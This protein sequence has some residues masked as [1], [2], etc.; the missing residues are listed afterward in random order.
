MR[1]V[2]TA[3][4]LNGRWS[5][6]S[7]T[8]RDR[9]EWPP[10]A[11]TLF[12]ALVA[13]A[14]SL[15]NAQHPALYWLEQQGNP[16]IEA[17]EEPPMVHGTISYVPVGDITQFDRGSRKA[18]WHNSVGEAAPVSWSWEIASTD[19]V[20]SLEQIAREV[21]YIGS[22][23]GPVMVSICVTETPITPSALVPRDGG[24]HR[25]RG[26]YRGRL[27]DLE[28]AFQAGQRPRPCQAV[29]YSRAD[30]VEIISPW[31]QLIPLRRETGPTLTLAHTIPLAEAIRR[32]ITRHLP[33]G[34]APALTGHT[35]DKGILRGE[36]LAI[37]PMPFVGHEHAD[38]RLLG[39]GLMLPRTLSDADYG[40]LIQALGAWL[41]DGGH[42]DMGALE[43]KM[44]V[45]ADDHRGSLKEDRFA[46]QSV[47]WSSVTP[48]AFDRH[49]RRTLTAQDVVAAMCADV[50]LPE[51]ESVETSPASSIQGA[52]ASRRHYLG[53]RSYLR[54]KPI[55]HVRIT[56]KR[57]IPGPVLL[58]RG[59][60]FGLGLML[61]DR[62]P[63]A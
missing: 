39:A 52:E 58:G 47:T 55:T 41:Q 42:V 57:P 12:S 54:D 8:R 4:P 5:I 32:A 22:S 26:I 6:S 10:S 63:A 37:V 19:H 1:L 21:P 34:A 16:V 40:A 61:P 35:D 29:G 45:A 50:G 9:A 38:G 60:Y 48:V 44:A 28:A 2:I 27:D 30:E 43:W 56:W 15:G 51:P 20:E 49:P 11:D 31:G 24:V 62:R 33:D 3:V 13:S 53:G 59:R 18:R 46:G 25:I 23:R 14:A 7:A 17:A 36:H